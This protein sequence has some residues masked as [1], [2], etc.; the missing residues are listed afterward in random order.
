M[1]NNNKIFLNLFNVSDFL[2]FFFRDLVY[3]NIILNISFFQFKLNLNNFVKMV[4]FCGVLCRLV[5]VCVCVC[6]CIVVVV[7]VVWVFCLRSVGFKDFIK[8]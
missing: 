8:I 1:H 4:I 7:V 2:F 3:L 5:C 6:V